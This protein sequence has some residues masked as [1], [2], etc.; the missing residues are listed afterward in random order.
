MADVAG[1]PLL[2]VQVV[3]V[4]RDGRFVHGRAEIGGVGQALRVSVIG[5]KSQAAVEP[6]PGVHPARVVPAPCSV[7]VKN[8]SNIFGNID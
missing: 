5:E 7:F 6:P 2:G 8:R 4:L 3:V 1:K